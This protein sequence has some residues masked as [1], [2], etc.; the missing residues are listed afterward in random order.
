VIR[1]KKVS[2]SVML[3]AS[4][5]DKPDFVGAL[6]KHFNYIIIQSSAETSGA[7]ANSV[8]RRI[9]HFQEISDIINIAENSRKSQN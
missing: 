7:E 4:Q 1:L 3:G 9:D 8:C 2:F 6:L 5:M